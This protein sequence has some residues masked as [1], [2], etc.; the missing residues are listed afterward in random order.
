MAVTATEMQCIPCQ[1]RK[2]V[3]KTSFKTKVKTLETPFKMKWKKKKVFMS[4]DFKVFYAQIRQVIPPKNN[5]NNPI[6][7]CCG[8]LDEPLRIPH[9]CSLISLTKGIPQPVQRY[10]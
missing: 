6:H 7:F 3:T 10:M 4:P 2:F 1:H 8:P 5:N 9:H